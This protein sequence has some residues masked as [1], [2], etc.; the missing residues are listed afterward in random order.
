M[1]NYSVYRHVN[2]INHKVYIG[3]TK[4]KVINRW[5][6]G[7]GYDS[8]YFTRAIKKYGWDNFIHEVIADGLS[9]EDACELERIL[10]KAHNS[11]C[12][13]F[14]YNRTIGG[15]G[16]GMLNHHHTD[17]AKEKIRIARKKNGFSEEHKKHIS[18]AKSGVNHHFAKKVYQF[19][20]DGT[21]MREWAYMSLAAKELSISK[22]NIG[23]VCNKRRKTAGGFIWKYERE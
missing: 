19:A 3:I 17:E 10:I 23:E 16:G 21:F 4:Q 9:K 20:L 5:K 1:D 13:E 18:E 11:S 6:N 22:G 7:K 14:G 8:Q 12:P 15:E 2:K